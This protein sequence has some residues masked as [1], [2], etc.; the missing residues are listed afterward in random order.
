MNA[1]LFFLVSICVLAGCQQAEQ[2]TPANNTPGLLDLSQWDINDKT[3][4]ALEGDWY[5]FWQQLLP[6]S[7]VFDQPTPT[8]VPVPAKWTTHDLPGITITPSG[9]AT[10]ALKLRLPDTSQ[11][12]GLYI[13]S[14]GVAYT[15]W[16]D[17]QEVVRSGRV[18]ETKD[19][20]VVKKIP[21]VVFFQPAQQEVE[22]VLHISNYHFR[23]GGFH[24][25]ILLGTSST[26]HQLHLSRWFVN[27]S[28]LAVYFIIGLYHIGLYFFHRQN[29]SPL[30]FALLCWLLTIRVSVTGQDIL[31]NYIPAISWE[32]SLRIEYLTFYWSFASLSLF[33]RSLYPEDVSI[34]FVRLSAVPAIF[35]T[36]HLLFSDTLTMSYAPKS[37]QILL[38]LQLPYL[39]YVFGRILYYRRQESFLVGLA[40][41]I[42]VLAGVLDIFSNRNNLPLYQIIPFAFMTFIFL[43]AILLSL[44]SS[45]AF[46]TIDQMQI[47][48]RQSEHKYRAIFEESQDMIFLARLDGHIEDVSPACA[49]ILG[50]QRQVLQTMN[51]LQLVVDPASVTHLQDILRRQSTIQDFETQLRGQD[52]QITDVA[53]TAVLRHND[54]N[55]VIGIQ[56]IVRDITDKKQA[57]A[58]RLR[59]LEMQ[60][61]KETAEAANKAKST[62]LA[63]MSH[64]LRSPL[65]AILGFAQVMKRSQTLD[66]EHQENVGIIQRSGEHLL[67][68]INQILDLSKIEAGRITLNTRDFD[69]HRLLDDLEDMFSLKADDKHLQLLFDRYPDVPQYIQTDEVKLRQV[70]INLLNNALK[71]TE[72]GGVTVQIGVRRQELGT[73]DQ[74]HLT[75]ISFEVTDTGPGMTSDDL[76][77]L[78]EAFVQTELGRQAQE[79]TGLGLSISRSFVRLMGGDMKVESQVGRGTTFLFDIEVQVSADILAKQLTRQVFALE[80]NQPRY[81]ILIVDDKWANR[82][83]LRKLLEPLGFQI[84]DA[85]NGKVAIEIAQSFKPHLI[86]MDIRMPVMDGMEAVK[87]LKAMPVGQ[88]MKIIVLTASAYEEGRAEIDAVGCDDFV[89]KPI[90]ADTVF[91]LLS[92]HI[93]VRYVYADAAQQQVD[94][95]HDILPPDKIKAALDIISAELL[96]RLREGVEL[97]DIKVIDKTIAE[98]REHHIALAEA[99]HRLAQRFQFDE[100]LLLLGRENKS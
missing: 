54:A 17:G 51:V 90:Q 9:Y 94:S 4:I 85:E 43:Q 52:G 29:R 26:I 75:H 92:K 24:N 98:I 39:L 50:Y 58:E 89:R 60:K 25:E 80:P 99:L 67:T 97:G 63:N 61:A 36:I 84:R 42:L 1:R 40:T 77:S 70:L 10:Y 20:M 11:T 33:I 82:Q 35:Y 49:L 15:M 28:L 74:E 73:G 12:Y 47:S 22:L 32:T 19:T 2:Y 62:F 91:E 5:F 16:I 59:T 30:Y 3:L 57:E 100:L 31:L 66:V 72:E 21:Q 44:R 65:N 45:R 8:Y 87:R 79:G 41:L 93:G 81:R 56:G 76:D 55:K 34:K 13:D 71:F 7:E 86:W 68:L 83:L 14:E 48:L 88:T 64:E 53:I 78:F 18:G 96:V 95:D 6:P 38:L 46:H 37:Y 23:K 69:L 27:V